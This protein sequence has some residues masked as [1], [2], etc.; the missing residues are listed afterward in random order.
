MPKELSETVVVCLIDDD[1]SQ[2][3]EFNALVVQAVVERFDHSD[4]APVIVLFVEF[5]DLAV[6]DFVRNADIRQ[7]PARLTT[8]FNAVRQNQYALARFQDVAL[9]QF[10][11]DDR[12]PTPRWQLKQQVVA[13]WKLLHPRHERIDGIFLVPV[14]VFPFVGFQL[15]LQIEVGQ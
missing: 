13:V 14:E 10:R 2:I 8:Q 9:G 3:F 15:F 1:Q 5:L 11:E 12:L 7:H 6:D 4:K